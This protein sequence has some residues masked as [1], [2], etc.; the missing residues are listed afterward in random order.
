MN[1]MSGKDDGKRAQT[2]DGDAQSRWGSGSVVD[3]E[4]RVVVG[5]WTRDVL[6][7]WCMQWLV[8]RGVYGGKQSRMRRLWLWRATPIP[9]HSLAPLRLFPAALAMCASLDL[10]SNPAYFLRPGTRAP[11]GEIYFCSY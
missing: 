8:E 11:K 10:I 1:S 3:D 9:F 7:I 5:L 6:E 2:R 4:L